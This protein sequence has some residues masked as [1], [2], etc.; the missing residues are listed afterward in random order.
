MKKFADFIV[1]KRNYILAFMLILAAVCVFL[2]PKVG[3]NSDMTK[4]LSDSSSMKQGITLMEKK[5]P[6]EKET[7]TVRVMF[8]GLTGE[9]KREIKEKLTAISNVESVEYEPDS[10]DYN[11]E[12][13]T[14]YV[15]NTKY[16]YDTAEEKAIENQVRKDYSDFDITLK[17]DDTSAPDIPLSVYL[18]AFGI[19]LVVL[20]IS[21]G[22][23]FEP[24][25]FL[26]T[27]GIAVVLNLGT[28]FF[29]GEISDVSFGIA[30][31]LQL[32]LSMDYSIILMNRYRQELK[33]T[34]D[35]KEAMANALRAAFGAITGSAV[36]TVVGLLVLVFMSFKIGADIGIVL[37]KGVALSMVCVFTVLPALILLSHRLIEKTEK[38][39]KD[40]KNKKGLS[41]ALGRFSYRF[42]GIIAALF[43]LIFLGTGYL[44]SGTKTVYTLAEK[45]AIADIFPKNNPLVLLYE[46]SDED[47]IAEIAEELQ[48]S[49]GAKSVISYPTTI[50]RQ[51][52]A[53]EMVSLLSD[54]EFN[55]DEKLLNIIYCRYNSGGK[56]KPMTLPS[57]I[58]FLT[59]TVSSDPLFSGSV[60][61]DAA[62][63]LAALKP[64]IDKNA[65]TAQMLSA[66]LAQS[67]G[68]DAGQT[69]QIF[70]LRYG[71]EY[72]PDKTMSIYEFVT[73]VTENVLSDP[74]YASAFD[75]AAKIRLYQVKAI[76]DA[77]V[78]DREFLPEEMAD[79][80]GGISE[81]FDKTT[82]E[83]LY[84]YN[85][86]LTAETGTMSPKQL[87]E[88]LENLS[89]EPSLAALITAE[90]KTGIEKAKAQIDDG[91]SLLKGENYSRLTVTTVLPVESEK[92]AEF[93]NKIKGLC[94][95]K[96]SGKY[97][98]VGNSAMVDEMENRFDSELLFIT[99]LTALS[100]FM[101]V[102]ITF[103]S[104]AVPAILVLIVQCG[105][106]ITVSALGIA[107]GSMYYLALLIVECILMGATID[108]GILFTS[109]YREM[110]TT[111]PVKEALIGAY[112]GS[113]HTILTSGTIMV[114]ITAVIGPL[115]ENPA[116]E[117][118][119]R[120]LAVGCASAIFLIMFILPGILALLDR[121]AVGAKNKHGK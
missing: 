104:L 60:D 52:T 77:T 37:A 85:E 8:R 19:I 88:Y 82:V 79:F 4:Y 118:I 9:E 33:K 51:Y 24:V 2:I 111:L 22:S 108:Y 58:V 64:L 113:I 116:I 110:R 66:V 100:V 30:A 105:V 47:K 36:T 41:D 112:R 29:L 69:A 94:R 109:Y 96:L 28:N 26:I 34:D 32:A 95:E 50:G 65:L 90:Q 53:K 25:L 46:N 71:T 54:M 121:L 76:A 35:R 27:I 56:I 16:G 103:R 49:D 40:K 84:L 11:T 7:Y 87:A 43:V 20:L 5:F 99:M 119:V 18:A 44:Q 98:L 23:Y 89:G 75:D 114:L 106:F 93:V 31:V 101:V 59:E 6:E 67:I 86:S 14:L 117:Q 13:F 39:K 91:T 120:T 42:R 83:L 48:K 70:M 73:F 92:T 78:G 45:D 80:L 102:A 61:A 107:G 21:C 1:N 62:A 12:D 74:K 68:M 115:F 72:S 38:K 63:E 10:E 17:N 15:L 57:F 55:V 3:V 97:Y 81:K